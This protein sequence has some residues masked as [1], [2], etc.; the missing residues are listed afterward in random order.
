MKNRLCLFL[1]LSLW[2]YAAIGGGYQVRLQGQKQT[3]IGLIG[4]PFAPDA[5]SIF[6]NPGGLALVEGK[7]SLSAGVSGIMSHTVFQ[8]EGTN[9]QANTDNPLSTPFYLYFSAKIK[10]MIAVGI[11]VYTPFG[12]SVQWDEDWAGRYLIRDISLSAICIQPTVAYQYKE[13]F[14]IGAGFVYAI[15]NV[16]LSKAL[17]YSDESSVSLEGDASNFGFNA[18]IFYKPIEKLNIGV[19][20]RSKIM[21]NLEDGE[22]TFN[23]PSAL[24][25]SV[26]ENNK[27]SADLPLPANLDFGL[28]YQLTEKFLLAAEVNWVMWSAYE[29]L[30][31]EFEESGELL[32]SQNPRQYKD[33]WITRLGGEYKLNDVFTFRAGMYYDP[34][35]VNEAYFTPET[36]SLNN[37]AFTLGLSI[38][39]V[40]GLDIDIS[41]LEIHGLAAEK[42][43]TPDNFAGTYKNAAFIPGIGL[44]Y[45]F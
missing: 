33:S 13:K 6:Y 23:V 31:F 3:G 40:K 12:S 38:T 15:G 22:A 20:Y 43:Y 34:S 18:G 29:S 8:K 30:D 28:S 7:F 10:D 44:H 27:F 2:A 24:S 35:P 36:V 42:T 32:N 39:P 37:I 11:G 25:T 16:E 5:S 45:R 14:G 41:Y 1:L 19:S 17:P 21:M 9:Y 26:P 4:T